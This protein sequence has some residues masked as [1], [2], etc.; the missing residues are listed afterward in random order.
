M[1]TMERT[2]RWYACVHYDSDGT[3]ACMH[4]ESGVDVTPDKWYACIEMTMV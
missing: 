2:S 4:D 3:D 1:M